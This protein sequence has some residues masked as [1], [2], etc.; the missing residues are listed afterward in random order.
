MIRRR[1]M[2]GGPIMTGSRELS[3]RVAMLE[4]QQLVVLLLRLAVAASLASI[5]VR[6]TAFQ[7]MLMLEDRTV[8]QRVKLALS[9]TAAFG[10]GV[11]VRVLNPAYQAVD[12]GLEG[13]FLSGLVGGY[14]TGLM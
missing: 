11:A 8:M 13:S 12:L 9:L 10:A 1:I 7:R 2:I 4:Q 6:F 5:L 3:P 14:M